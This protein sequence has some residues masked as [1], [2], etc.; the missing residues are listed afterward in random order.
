M[1]HAE[2]S[3][4]GVVLG[5]VESLVVGAGRDLDEDAAA[6]TGE[7][8]MVEGHLDGGKFGRAFDTGFHIGRDADV[9][10]LR[11]ETEAE[12]EGEQASEAY[13][14]PVCRDATGKATL[15]EGFGWEERICG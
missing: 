10:V 14:F 1:A 11:V 13:R 7:G 2:K 12:Q 4:V 3:D 15:G 8:V 6:G 5:D 9:N